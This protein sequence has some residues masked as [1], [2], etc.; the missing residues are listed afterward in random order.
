LEDEKLAPPPGRDGSRVAAFLTVL[1][2]FG[3]AALSLSV[4][5]PL[6]VPITAATGD[7]HLSQAIVVMP[8]LGLA[9]TSLAAG[10]IAEKLGVRG[11]LCAGALAFVAVGVIGFLEPPPPLLLADCF[12]IGS[13]AALVRVG[14]GLFLGQAYEGAARARV[15][16]Y[17]SAFAALIA[18]CIV[19]IAGVIADQAGW[20]AAFLLF[21]AAGASVL[22]FTLIA[23][24]NSS[25]ASADGDARKPPLRFSLLTP[26]IPF[27]AAVF[28]IMLMAASTGAHVPLM[29][30]DAGVSSNSAV[31]TVLS[32]QALFGMLGSLAYGQLA[33]R[34]GRLAVATL[35]VALL[36]VAGGVIATAHVLV[37]FGVGC[38]VL[39]L[40]S[41]LLMPWLYE[42]LFTR[43]PLVVRGYAIGFYGACGNIGAFVN[44]FVLRPIR[45]AVGLHGLYGVLAAAAAV[46]GGAF[47]VTAF[48]QGRAAARRVPGV[49]PATQ[50]LNSD[51]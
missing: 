5:G 21:T 2:G 24:R 16:G 41:G 26:V 25:A 33:P 32:M 27:F 44:P 36:M 10:W 7:E 9:I 40:A 1:M 49:P 29:I 17:A 38:A 46:I 19:A 22:A 15:I 13:S 30:R 34:L 14:A 18:A 23:V 47:L 11:T 12:L 6:L 51:P 37:M 45:E 50:P 31:S 4:I 43:A 3:T 28:L 20:N 42:G 39:G 35:G 8:F 48:N